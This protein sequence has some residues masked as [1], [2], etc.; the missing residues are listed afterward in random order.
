MAKDIVIAVLVVVIISAL[1]V[2]SGCLPSAKK[3]KT[4]EVVTPPSGWVEYQKRNGND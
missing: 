3:M 2:L 1:I 4:G